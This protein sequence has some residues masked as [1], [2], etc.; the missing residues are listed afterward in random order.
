[1]CSFKNCCLVAQQCLT[2][3]RPQWTVAGQAPLSIQ[4][5]RQEYWSGLPFPSAG[6]FLT[7]GLNRHLLHWQ[8]DSLPLSHQ[9]SL[10][11]LKIS[12]MLN[13]DT[14]DIYACVYIYI[15]TVISIKNYY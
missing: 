5:S 14:C 12:L 13:I 9:G 3:L 2:L 4:F 6:V 11:H 15:H 10:V 1:M 7:Q 8:V